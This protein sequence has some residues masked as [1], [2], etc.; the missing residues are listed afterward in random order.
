M[1]Y[2]MG[3]MLT[4]AAQ[5]TGKIDAPGVAAVASPFLYSGIPFY[6]TFMGIYT[7]IADFLNYRRV[8]IKLIGRLLCFCFSLM[9]RNPSRQHQ[10]KLFRLFVRKASV[11]VPIETIHQALIWAISGQLLSRDSKI[12]YREEMIKITSKSCFIAGDKDIIATPEAV[13][14]GY[15]AVNSSQKVYR[16]LPGG[17]HMTLAA[18]KNARQVAKIIK[19]WSEL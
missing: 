10:L 7:K 5:A 19:E 16:I 6:P 2:S 11:D 17:D 12:N 9:T 1:G 3:G 13:K 4:M 14:E 18:G 15:L 8:P